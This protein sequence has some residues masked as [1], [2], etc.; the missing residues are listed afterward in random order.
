MKRFD[1]TWGMYKEF[2][3]WI[4]RDKVAIE[5]IG[6]TINNKITPVISE[7]LLI[8]YD[9]TNS[10]RDIILQGNIIFELFT[11]AKQVC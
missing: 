6:R 2:S 7:G 8:I 3:S 11:L 1:I 9:Q 5:R 4:A 10:S